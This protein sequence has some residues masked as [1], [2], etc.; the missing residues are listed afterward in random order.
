MCQV[1][2]S[3]LICAMTSDFSRYV[4]DIVITDNRSWES[5]GRIKTNLKT[6]VNCSLLLDINIHK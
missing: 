5:L 1:M 2:T 6:K 3:H 4:L